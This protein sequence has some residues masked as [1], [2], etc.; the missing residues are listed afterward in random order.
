MRAYINISLNSRKPKFINDIDENILKPVHDKMSE[1]SCRRIFQKIWNNYFENL[2]QSG[3]CQLVVEMV[4]NLKFREMMIILGLR[5]SKNCS[6]R[7]I[8]R[9]LFDEYKYIGSK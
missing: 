5:T 2:N 9:N 7:T 8:V 6:E 3:R 1:R 4:K